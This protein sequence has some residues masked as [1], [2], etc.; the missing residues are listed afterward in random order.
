MFAKQAL[1]LSSLA[2]LA[3]AH[4]TVLGVYIFHRHGDRTAK[5]FPPTELTDLGYQQVYTSGE[6]FRSK[7]IDANATSPII[8]I[9]PNIVKLSQLSVE[10]A[11]DNVLQNSAAGF[12]Q[13]LYPPVGATLG[14]ETLANGTTV[15][16]PLSGFQ[17]IPVNVVTSASASSDTSTEDSAWLQ[18]S[19]GCNN[20]VLS[21]NSYLTSAEYLKTLNSTASFYNS[22]APV[23]NNTFTS[24]YT[25]FKNA[26]SVYDLIHVSSIHNT[27][28]QDS[29]VLTNET[30]SQLLTLANQHEFGLAYN[31][32]ETIR[33]IAG[34][35]LAAQILQQLNV[36]V[37]GE[38][39]VPV[40]IQFGAYSS[41]LS[42]FGLAQLPEVSDDF[43]G[44]A[45]YASSMTFELT[46]NATVSNTS[47]PTADQI[48]VSF[49]FTNSSA[50]I[51][52]PVAYPL[53][54]Q[55]ETSLPWT[56]F[57]TEMNKFAIGTQTQWCNACGNSTGVCATTADASSSNSS[58]SSASASSSSSG[59]GM[60][61]T[62]AGVIGAFVTL[63]VILGLEAL[64][65][66]VGGLRIAKKNRG[67]AGANSAPTSDVKA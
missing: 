53:F 19:S 45:G 5:A 38:S 25:T 31:S 32:S 40:G 34:S 11:V 12:L 27:T 30:L 54:G 65:L 7:Y 56:T 2:A 66:L 61:R 46:T 33:A 3:H 62:V 28:L 17:L 47:Y 24:A 9:S 48:N 49:L 55:S 37:T 41:F 39:A 51:N 44:V 26:Y 1:L 52:P 42:F 35:T 60:S 4:E 21:S 36:T 50:A 18:G 20:A 23:V 57:V 63:V 10:A 64:V 8:N 58:L 22:V 67:G 59:G 15:E 16:S 29:A 6:W 13:G 14:A 43:T